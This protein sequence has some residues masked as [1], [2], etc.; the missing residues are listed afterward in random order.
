MDGGKKRLR[1]VAA[2]HWHGSAFCAGCAV[3]P[4]CGERR[5]RCPYVASRP[6]SEEGVAL[7]DLVRATA[8]VRRD[9]MSGKPVGL[10]HAQLLALAIARGLDGATAAAL[11]PPLEAGVVIGLPDPDA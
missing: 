11:L 3:D 8:A 2:W 6:R 1:D 4:S 9:A 7:W 10:D 5:Q